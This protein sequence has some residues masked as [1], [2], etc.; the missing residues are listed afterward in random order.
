MATLDQA[1]VGGPL[2]FPQL[3]TTVEPDDGAEGERWQHAPDQTTV[4][5]PASR[6]LWQQPALYLR[7]LLNYLT[8]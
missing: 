7:F 6:V 4:G 3:D 8:F 1:S 2:H 5:K